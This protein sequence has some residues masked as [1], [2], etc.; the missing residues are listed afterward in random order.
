M[1]DEF[2]I[3][4]Y[5]VRSAGT[6][7]PPEEVQAGINSL[8]RQT[9]VALNSLAGGGGTIPAGNVTFTQTGTGAAQRTVQ[10]KL[11]DVVS[12]LDF[13]G[14]DPTGVLDSSTGIQAALNSGAKAVYVPHGTYLCGGLVMPATFGFVLYG[15]GTASIL[16]QNTSA[17]PL[18]TWARVSI[19]YQEG[20]IRD[21]AFKGTNGAANTIDTSGVG[22]ET[23]QNLY[24]TDVPVGFSSI[25]VNGLSATQVHDIRL[26]NIQ[27]YS[28]TA[29]F[30]GVR[31][32]PLAFDSSM[33]NMIMNGNFVT[34]YCVYYDIGAA[35]IQVSDSHPYNALTNIV[36]M[37]GSN[38]F[39][40][41]SNVVFDNS[42]SDLVSITNSGNT[43]FTNS[44][45]ENIPNGKSGVRLSNT[46]DTSVMNSLFFG[47]ATAAAAI[48]EVAGSNQTK[49]IGGAIAN[50]GNFTA[51][52][53]FIG[54]NSYG[55]GMAGYDT[56]T[57]GGPAPLASPAFTGTPTAPTQATGD[58]SIRLATTAFVVNTF[59][60]P[61]AL[62][63][64]TPAAVNATTLV[65]SG[66]SSLGGLTGAEALR[67]VTTASA[68][69]WVQAAGA[70][71]G[72]SVLLSAQGSDS[73]VSLSLSSKG[74]FGVNFYT[75][76]FARV[77][78]AVNDTA[79]ANRFLTLTGS[80]G[81]NPTIGASAG[82][83]AFST[84]I[85]P[86]ST[87]GIVGTTTNDNANAGSVG[88]FPTPTNLTN[89]SLTTI[90]PANVSSVSLTAGDWD[91]QGTV[92]YT[93]AGSTTATTF[94]SGISTTSA[95]LGANGTFSAQVA[96][97]TAGG[98]QPSITSP[99]V[100]IS[101]ASTTTVY[102]IADANFS[103]STCTASGFLRARRIR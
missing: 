76:N 9:T 47:Q 59:A 10:S 29:G 42:N 54:A 25:Y 65:A 78:V 6:D 1:A 57:S 94:V 19:N 81:G 16:V 73:N 62:G 67:A 72:N 7:V 98:G 87:N 101:I 60:A 99:T 20:Y 5:V 96:T 84:G 4:P 11:T 24:F 46:T 43:L 45:F 48:T 52:F 27:I 8:A 82:N 71:T 55:F 68:V 14:V 15:E 70:V 34:Q 63:S 33:A 30:S 102:L 74:T 32:G 90:T 100:R 35:A 51:A 89:V 50:L 61:P 40:M 22:G 95:T 56:L 80:N 97:Y 12:V 2:N 13:P 17:S 38:S 53:A 66:Q 44:Y 103:V 75:G 49:V 18:I 3:V 21:L 77:Q 41:F 85:V 92:M 36:N 64:T 28:N 88:E 79:S 39:N 26:N 23:L 31:W 37:A 86:V 58:N 69:N 93:P 91:V 83:V